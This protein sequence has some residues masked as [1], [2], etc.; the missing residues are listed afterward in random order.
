MNLPVSL[1]E[2]ERRLRWWGRRLD[3]SG[4]GSDSRSFLNRIHGCSAG[5]WG[6]R[7]EVSH[8]STEV[9]KSEST[10][11]FGVRRCRT[12]MILGKA[13]SSAKLSFAFL[14]CKV[15][16]SGWNHKEEWHTSQRIGEKRTFLQLPLAQM[17]V[18][19]DLALPVTTEHSFS[20]CM[21]IRT[22]GSWPG[23][24]AT[25]VLQSG[26]SGKCY[27]SR[28][29]AVSL[30]QTYSWERFYYIC[31][32]HISDTCEHRPWNGPGRKKVHSDS[33]WKVES[34]RGGM[35]G[36]STA[37]QLQEVDCHD[38]VLWMRKP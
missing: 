29:I 1:A 3:C 31:S 10:G 7:I 4:G 15:N 28:Y 13:M 8:S 37:F 35:M 16:K 25:G 21:S 22:F 24:I 12:I 27:M 9:G 38:L 2:R 20:K 19:F 5:C 11:R 23:R 30:D 32:C 18:D 26:P 36:L 34:R 17:G 33:I 14:L 6:I